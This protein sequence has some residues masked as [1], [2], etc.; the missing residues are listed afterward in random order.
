MDPM[1]QYL[2]L[3]HQKELRVTAEQ[4]RLVRLAR[5]SRP[6]WRVRVGLLF[7]SLGNAIAGPPEPVPAADCM[8]Y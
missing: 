3:E 7:I 1:S 6:R 8:S 4:R 5:S 2:A